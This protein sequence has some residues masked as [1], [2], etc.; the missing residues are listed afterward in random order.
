MD[1]Q[2]MEKKL[3]E[4]AYTGAEGEKNPYATEGF[5]RRIDEYMQKNPMST[6]ELRRNAEERH[7]AFLEAHGDKPIPQ[8]EADYGVDG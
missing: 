1:N 8:P 7:K 4:P 5:E 2:E 3:R 6:E